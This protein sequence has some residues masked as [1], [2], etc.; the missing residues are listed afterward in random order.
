MTPGTILFDKN[1]VFKDGKTGKK[2]FVVLNDGENE[3]YICVKTTSKSHR[4]GVVAG[5]QALDRFPS[6]FVPRD[7]SFLKQNTWIQLEVFYEFG[8]TELIGKVVLG[9]ILRIGTL[10]KN[11]T[12]ELLICGTHSKDI[13]TFQRQQLFK[14]LNKL[15]V[16]NLS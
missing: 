2:L 16:A 9:E 12:K 13:T 5:C 6:F 7:A 11:L 3:I 14:Q 8:R 15:G 10:N 1:F 4:Y